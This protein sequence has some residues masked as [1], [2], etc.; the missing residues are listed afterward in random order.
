MD[1]HMN[2]FEKPL[3]KQEQI[4]L[5]DAL[6]KFLVMYENGFADQLYDDADL[7]AEDLVHELAALYMIAKKLE[8]RASE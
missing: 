6:D 7:S 1:E 8:N 2:L 3:T 5:S 4:E